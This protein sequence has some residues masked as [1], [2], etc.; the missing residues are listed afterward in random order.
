[1]LCSIHALPGKRIVQR[2]EIVNRGNRWSADQEEVIARGQRRKAVLAK[3]A[4]FLSERVP[5]TADI[6]I[7]TS[8]PRQQGALRS[9]VTPPLANGEIFTYEY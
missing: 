3:T 8:K 2:F 5:A 4:A 1:M 6:W 9:F 7:A